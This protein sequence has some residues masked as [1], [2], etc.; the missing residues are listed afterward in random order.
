MKRKNGTRTLIKDKRKRQSHFFRHIIRK[1]QIDHTVITHNFWEER[2]GETT[3]EDFGWSG[4]LA[5]GK[6]NHGIYK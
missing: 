4:S 2:Q 3:E 1:E 5:E 6:I